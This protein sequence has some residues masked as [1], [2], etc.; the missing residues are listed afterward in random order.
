MTCVSS[1]RF[2][3]A[4]RQSFLSEISLSFTSSLR[5]IDVSQSTSLRLLDR[6]RVLLE[7][8]TTSHSLLNQTAVLACSLCRCAFN[9]LSI[10]PTSPQLF[11]STLSSEQRSFQPK[12]ASAQAA[13]ENSNAMASSRLSDSSVSSQSQQ[14]QL[15]SC[16]YSHVGCSARFSPQEL[17][18]H[19]E[20]SAQSHLA[21]L[22]TR[23]KVEQAERS[24]AQEALHHAQKRCRLM[25]SELNKLKCDLADRSQPVNLKNT[26]SVVFDRHD[27]ALADDHFNPSKSESSSEASSH[28]HT[29]MLTAAS[30]SQLEQQHDENRNDSASAVPQLEQNKTTVIIRQDAQIRKLEKELKDTRQCLKVCCAKL[31][32]QQAKLKARKDKREAAASAAAAS[33]NGDAN[34][35]AGA[36]DGRIRPAKSNKGANKLFSGLPNS[37]SNAHSHSLTRGHS[38]TPSTIH[39]L[40]GASQPPFPSAAT[41][42][43]MRSVP[44]TRTGPLASHPSGA[45]LHVSQSSSPFVKTAELVVNTIKLAAHNDHA[46]H[47]PAHHHPLVL[48]YSTTPGRLYEPPSLPSSVVEARPTS[49]LSNSSSADLYPSLPSL[50]DAASSSPYSSATSS[51]SSSIPAA[52][53]NLSRASSTDSASD[54]SIGS[55]SGPARPNDA[56]HTLPLSSDYSSL[57]PV[58][59]LRKCRQGLKMSTGTY[60]SDVVPVMPKPHPDA[61]IRPNAQQQQQQQQVSQSAAAAAQSIASGESMPASA[62][63]R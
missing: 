34:Q 29:S 12:A 3:D 7:F 33:G 50:P 4:G 47:L 41:A 45:K 24:H 6:I 62:A 46:S 44:L 51:S 31:Q 58:V 52:Q 53:Y 30:L 19:L 16:L 63:A 15:V 27:S 14:H 22:V 5:P 13:T 8:P 35:G 11:S 43:A 48:Q 39:S 37:S 26:H 1:S 9:S 54:S 18:Q 21:L 32:A 57:C 25:E 61:F 17:E 49:S 10:G 36:A 56:Y 40:S 59:I 60:E 42:A 28:N 38:L 23:F 55:A 20:S 2:C